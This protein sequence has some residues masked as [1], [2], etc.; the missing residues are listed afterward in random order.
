MFPPTTIACSDPTDYPL[1]GLTLPLHQPLDKFER[2]QEE[3]SG[4]CWTAAGKRSFSRSL[5]LFAASV[6][7]V[8]EV[9]SLWHRKPSFQFSAFDEATGLGIQFLRRKA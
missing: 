1:K 8:W 2:R 9:S 3:R 4:A 7:S 6:A 5:V